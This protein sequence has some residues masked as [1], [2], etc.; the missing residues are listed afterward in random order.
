MFES[1]I[2]KTEKALKINA[3]CLK[4]LYC[5]HFFIA[6]AK[7]RSETPGHMIFND[8]IFSCDCH[9]SERLF[10]NHASLAAHSAGHMQRT[11]CLCVSH[12]IPKTG[13]S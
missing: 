2:G 5:T 1:I 4:K 8:F 6:S 10:C 3:K 9:T 11:L 13:V 12:H 7:M